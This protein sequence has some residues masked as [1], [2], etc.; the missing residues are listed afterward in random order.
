MRINTQTRTQTHEGAPAKNISV[1]DQLKRSVLSCLLWEKQFYE[2]GEDI[3]ERIIRLSAQCSKEF[4]SSLAIRAR[5]EYKL[6]HAPLLLLCDLIS[7]GGAGVAETIEST[8]NR[9]DE[10]TEL[11]AIYWRDGKRPISKQMKLGLSK[12]FCKFDE[13]QLSKWNRPGDIKIRDIMFLTHP[14]P[15]DDTQ[16]ELFKRV[17]SDSLSTPDTWES[18][19]AAGGDKKEVFTDLLK[20]KKL[21]YMA[22]LRNLRNMIQAGVDE[23]LVRDA[24]SRPSVVV[25][26]YRFIAASKHA[27]MYERDLDRAMLKILESKQRINGRTAILVDV[28]GSMHAPLSSKSDLTRI[29]AANGLAILLAGICENLRVF[30][31]SHKVVEVPARQGMALGDAIYR[32]QPHGGTWLGNAVSLVDQQIPYDRLIVITDEQSHDRVPDPK[33]KGYMINVASFKNGIG[34]QSWTHI[35]GFSEACVDFIQEIEK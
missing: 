24:I 9:P 35:D 22:L 26:P 16:K 7:R 2:S 33:G 32:S 6:R 31:F 30:T 14:K 10:L 4:V 13:Y 3:A 25:L 29:D 12:A 23:S 34:Y 28:S 18:K 19:M 5:T 15:K 27:P 11:L 21:G 1:E 17:A 20:R 8:I